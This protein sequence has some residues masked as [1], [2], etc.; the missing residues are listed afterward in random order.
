MYNAQ[1]ID[2]TFC[3]Y[4]HSESCTTGNFSADG[5]VLI[6]ASNDKSLRIWDLKNRTNK[7]KIQG[8]KY[9]KAEILCLAIGKE[10]SLVATGSGLNEVGVVNYESGQVKFLYIDFT[11]F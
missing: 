3:L 6:T 1:N 11:F 9:H 2:S 4:G 8:K 7:Y 10:K 5:K